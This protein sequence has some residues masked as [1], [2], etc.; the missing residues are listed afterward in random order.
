MPTARGPYSNAAN[1]A[2]CKER[3]V[4][5]APSKIPL[6]GKSPRNVYSVPAQETAKRRAKFGWPL[7]NDVVAVTKPRCE[8][9][10]KFAGVHQT[11]QQILAASGPKFAI[12]WMHVEEILLFNKFFFRLSIRSLVSKF[13][14]DKFV[15]WCPDGD[16]LHHFCILYF[17]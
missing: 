7:V 9:P 2:E 14:P 15:R 17:K 1:I 3:R 12:L 10:L 11:R 5:F 13:Q 4:N 6:Q 16:F 8:N